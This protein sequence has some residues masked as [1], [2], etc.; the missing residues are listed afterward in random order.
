MEKTAG[1]S[2][3]V[4]LFSLASFLPSLPTSGKHPISFFSLIF[5]SVE[6]KI[7]FV[8]VSKYGIFFPLVTRDLIRFQTWLHATRG[9]R[10]YEEFNA[11]N[12]LFFAAA[13]LRDV[14]PINEKGRGG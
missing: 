10:Q 7:G 2:C 12:T 8:C 4:H 13:S 6:R 14:R 1:V 3:L 9:I 11:L 5:L